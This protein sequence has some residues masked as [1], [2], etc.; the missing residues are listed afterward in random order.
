[1]TVRP[2]IGW[3]Q[4]AFIACT[5]SCIA[6]LISLM[7]PASIAFGVSIGAGVALLVNLAAVALAALA[8]GLSAEIGFVGILAA[9]AVR[10]VGTLLAAAVIHLLAPELLTAVL[11]TTC[12]LLL[13]VLVGESFQYAR[14]FLV[15][16]PSESARA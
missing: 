4:V 16:S 11:V 5:P 9:L 3:Q 14:R 1:M 15:H 6:G 10:V 8:M 13:A 2:V 12:V 7:L